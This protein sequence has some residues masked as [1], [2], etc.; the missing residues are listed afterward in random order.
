MSALEK[1][2]KYSVGLVGNPASA[3]TL[4]KQPDLGYRP[5]IK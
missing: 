5:E 2:I 3:G 4:G 1:L